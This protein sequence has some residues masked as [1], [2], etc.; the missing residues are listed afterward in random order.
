MNKLLLSNQDHYDWGLRAMKSVLVVAGGL[1]RGDPELSEEMVLMRALRDFNLPKIVASDFP[2]FMG[3]I[4]DL[5]LKM[6]LPRKQDLSFE[7][8]LKNTVQ[9]FG[10]QADES[11]LLKI[12]QLDQLLNV[13][14]SIFILG[15]V[16]SGKSQCWKMLA[17][18]YRALGRKLMLL[19]LN[20]KSVSEDE[21][22]GYI[23]KTTREWQ[24]GLLSKQ[25]RSLANTL[26]DD[27]KWLILDG[28]I[29]P[30]KMIASMFRCSDVCLRF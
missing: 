22:F 4:N 25:L 3:L 2:I 1:K 10:L 19:D 13:R 6:E 20:P 24:D 7:S 18:T 8:A 14:H 9:K 17:R 28:E 16:A 27:M 11:F 23:N 12:I 15:E 30:G 29:D 21:L 26:S 5:F